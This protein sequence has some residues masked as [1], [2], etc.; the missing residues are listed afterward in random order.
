MRKL[1]TGTHLAAGI[2]VHALPHLVQRGVGQIEAEGL[3]AAAHFRARQFPA[4]VAVGRLK[5]RRPGLERRQQALKL[6]Q[7][8]RTACC[9][10]TGGEGTGREGTGGQRTGAGEVTGEIGAHMPVHMLMANGCVD[11]MR[12]PKRLDHPLLRKRRDTAC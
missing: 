5:E 12:M 7:G 8:Q 11:S 10:W 2:V 6:G 9:R 1:S 4:A 3:Q